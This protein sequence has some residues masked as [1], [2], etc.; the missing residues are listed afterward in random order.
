MSKGS[1]VHFVACHQF[2]SWR[3]H[4]AFENLENAI[5]KGANCS[6]LLLQSP[7]G[8]ANHKNYSSRGPVSHVALW[9]SDRPWAILMNKEQITL[10]P[11]SKIEAIRHESSALPKTV[12]EKFEQL[13]EESPVELRQPFDRDFYKKVISCD[14]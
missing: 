13:F 11:K 1:Q 12:R 8:N 6:R 14:K 5:T 4:Q 7:S 9:Y 2:L 10:V 3:E